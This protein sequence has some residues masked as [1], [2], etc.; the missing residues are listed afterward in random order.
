MVALI[1]QSSLEHASC[2]A[3]GEKQSLY[4]PSF[5]KTRKEEEVASVQTIGRQNTTIFTQRIK[6]LFVSGDMFMC[7]TNPTFY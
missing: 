3:T 1:L 6:S 4:L 5:T 7:T 2:D